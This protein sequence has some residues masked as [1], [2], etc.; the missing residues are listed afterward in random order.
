MYLNLDNAPLT[1][2]VEQGMTSC[3]HASCKS[4]TSP[5]IIAQSLNLIYIRLMPS[6]SRWALGE[7]IPFLHETPLL[8]LLRQYIR[9]YYHVTAKHRKKRPESP[10][11]ESESESGAGSFSQID[12]ACLH[13][14]DHASADSMLSCQIRLRFSSRVK[15]PCEDGCYC[16]L[17]AR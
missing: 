5:A 12:P 10:K 8:S 17:S 14:S 9:Y 11:S 3:G 16:C 7:E 13:V 15:C 2:N 4:D 6:H 1:G